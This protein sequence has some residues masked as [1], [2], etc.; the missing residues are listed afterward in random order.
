MR[1]IGGALLVGVLL[2]SGCGAP[3]ATPAEKAA[4]SKKAR[5]AAYE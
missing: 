1:G 3:G 5:Q 4:A 2:L